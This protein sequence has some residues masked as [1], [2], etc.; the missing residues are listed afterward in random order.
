MQNRLAL[1]AAESKKKLPDVDDTKQVQC[2]SAASKRQLFGYVS[3]CE[4]T[5]AWHLH[6]ASC[7][8]CN[9][10]QKEGLPQ[11]ARRSDMDMNGHINNVVYVAWTLESV[12][13]DV[14][15]KYA[16]YEVRR[17]YYS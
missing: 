12:P 2:S 3:T 17:L 9:L 11:V 10:V 16:L 5:D 7:V 15:H 4:L 13:A 14:Y 6:M 8:A 1:P